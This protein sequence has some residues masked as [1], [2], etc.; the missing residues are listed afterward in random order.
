MKQLLKAVSKKTGLVAITAMLVGAGATAGVFAA[1]PDSNTGIISGCRNTTSGVLRAIDAQSNEACDS[2][3]TP[4]SIA[5][6]SAIPA[7]TSAML[8]LIPDP[9]NSQKFLFDTGRS[10]NI[11][12]FDI[13]DDPNPDN[14]ATGYSTACLQLAFTPEMSIGSVDDGLVGVGNNNALKFNQTW[15]QATNQ[16]AL[17]Y[18]CGSD[19]NAFAAITPATAVIGQSILF[20]K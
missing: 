1:I 2:S 12:K 8:R 19:Y 20:T 3:E 13:K 4:I 7:Q 15:E 18:Y 14:A 11:V 5:S 6:A 17:D 16:A 9:N 10:R